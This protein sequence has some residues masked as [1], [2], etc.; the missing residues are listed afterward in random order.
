M[1][2]SS[3]VT[4]SSISKDGKHS[5]QTKPNEQG[6]GVIAQLSDGIDK[7]YLCAHICFAKNTTKSDVLGRKLKQRTCTATIWAD[8]ERHLNMWRYKAE[9][10][11]LMNQNPP[12][13]LMSNKTGEGLRPSRFPLGAAIRE[14]EEGV[15]IKG[16]LRIPDCIILKISDTEVANLV[17]K[18]AEGK[19]SQADLKHFVPIQ[20]NIDTVVEIKF[21]GDKLSDEQIKAYKRIAGPNKFRE[22]KEKDCHCGVRRPDPRTQSY[23]NYIAAIKMRADFDSLFLTPRYVNVQNAYTKNIS[24]SQFAEK[25]TTATID[26]GFTDVAIVVTVAIA[27]SFFI[28]PVGGLTVGT[29]TGLMLSN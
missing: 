27:A 7:N 11:Y 1:G 25:P 16:N 26:F 28:S 19:G 21:E 6:T 12:M 29:A 4:P 8:E 10:G 3:G 14:I 15:G 2:R 20:D 17:K 22:L 23:L 24:F 13:P 5:T 9:V 18:F